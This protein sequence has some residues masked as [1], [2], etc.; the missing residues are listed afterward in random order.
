[1]KAAVAF[2]I[3][4]A[5]SLFEPPPLLAIPPRYVNFSFVL[6]DPI[7]VRIS[8]APVVYS[9]RLRHISVDV[10]PSLQRCFS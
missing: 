7:Q 10:Q 5:V 3:L 6:R 8:F 4:I 9:H 2:P 1:M